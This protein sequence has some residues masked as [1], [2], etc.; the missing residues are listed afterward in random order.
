MREILS[1]SKRLVRKWLNSKCRG[2]EFQA[3]GSAVYIGSEREFRSSFFER[4]PS[5]IKKS[6]TD[7][8]TKILE[9]SLSRSRSRSRRGRAYLDHP[10]SL[11]I[12]S[13]K[14]F[15]CLDVKCGRIAP[16]KH[17]LR[18]LAA[19]SHSCRCICSRGFQEIV[20]LNAG[21]ILVAEDNGT[22]KKWL[23]LI[24]RTLN[25]APDSSVG[26]G[27][28]TPSLSPNLWLSGMPTQRINGCLNASARCR[29]Q[30]IK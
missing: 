3:D 2:D 8:S 6:R 29:K 28:Y 23:A 25:N 30:V 20:P 11:N 13:Y 17:E 18:R 27:C 15:L 22:A 7:D 1:W 12:Q 5:T 9:R 4:E 26:T 14:F 21:N 16:K 19:L 10:Q 24:K